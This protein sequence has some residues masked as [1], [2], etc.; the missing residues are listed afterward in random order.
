MSPQAASDGDYALGLADQLVPCIT[1]MIEDLIVGVEDRVGEPVFPHELPDVFD[2][3]EFWTF[4]WQRDDAD[5]LGYDERG[6]H[7]P[8]G[9]IHEHYGM[10]AK[11]DSSSD[12]GQMQVHP[13]PGRRLHGNL[14][15]GASVLQSG[16]TSPAALP[17]AGQIAPKMYV[18]MVR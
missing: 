1:A 10:G 15:R 3:I 16:R 6:G 2:G 8:P 4:G 5:I 11:R 14:P 7:M 13:L 12:F 17:S 18:D 9:L